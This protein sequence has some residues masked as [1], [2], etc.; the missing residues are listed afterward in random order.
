[1]VAGKRAA[2]L[3]NLVQCG[4]LA[5]AAYAYHPAIAAVPVVTNVASVL[6]EIVAPG[7]WA[8]RGV[9]HI[10]PLTP[11]NLGMGKYVYKSNPLMDDP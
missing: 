3:G 6:F 8:D 1:M 11:V 9:L 5:Y 2:R 7:G 4:L 10:E